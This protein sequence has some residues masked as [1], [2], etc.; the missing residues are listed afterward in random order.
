MTGISNFQ[1]P[2]FLVKIMSHF[3]KLEKFKFRR[4][5][6]FSKIGKFGILRALKHILTDPVRVFFFFG[7]VLH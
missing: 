5:R 1:N 3:M 6:L 2:T 4:M 7:S